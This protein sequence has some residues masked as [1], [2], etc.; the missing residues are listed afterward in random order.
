MARRSSAPR[1][2][3]P[4]R[5]RGNPSDE[6]AMPLH[7]QLPFGALEAER[8]KI[9]AL[10]NSHQ[11]NAAAMRRIQRDLDLAKARLSSA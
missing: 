7:Q 3:R 6:V 4:K 8:R 11:I 5:R 1:G 2:K 10:Q 9:S